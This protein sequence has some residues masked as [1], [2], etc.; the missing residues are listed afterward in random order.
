MNG[1]GKIKPD[2]MQAFNAL[3]ILPLIP[4]FD[5]GIYPFLE[6]FGMP[7]TPLRRMGTGA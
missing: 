6:K 7:L 4:V 1:Y 5:Y 2:Q 3:F